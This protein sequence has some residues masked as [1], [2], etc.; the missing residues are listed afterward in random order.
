LIWG[1]SI[2]RLIRYQ[3]HVIIE[4][5]GLLQLR[6]LVVLVMILAVVVQLF[7][8]DAVVLLMLVAMRP[9][10]RRSCYRVLSQISIQVQFVKVGV[11]LGCSL[12][13]Y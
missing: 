2:S 3:W 7:R 8:V 10:T 9:W 11:F 4:P 6:A 12:L 1:I 13:R 5:L